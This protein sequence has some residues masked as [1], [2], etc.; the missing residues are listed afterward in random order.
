MKLFLTLLL[1]SSTACAVAPAKTIETL[2]TEYIQLNLSMTPHDGSFVDAYYGPAALQEQAVK[3]PMS[4]DEIKSQAT[5]MLSD[6]SKIPTPKAESMEALRI[7]YLQKQTTAM[8]GRIDLL[9]AKKM[10]FDQE[11]AILYDA[12]A[13]H[14]DRSHFEA[15]IKQIDT[16]LPGSGTTVERVKAFR[17]QFIIPRDKLMVV[18]ET[19]IQACR[20][21][22]LKHITLPEG[23]DFKLEFVTGKV[24]SGYNWYK[25]NYQSLI[26]INVELPIY[27]ERAIDIG[28]HE[29]YPGHHTYNVLLEKNLVNERKWLEY[30]VY[31]L[32][33]PQSLIAEGT[34]NYGVEMAFPEALKKNFQRDVLYP[35]AGI[36]PAL[37][38]KYDALLKL[39]AQLNY[40]GNEAAREYIDG[41][42]TREQAID[43][44]INV[45]L[46]PVE[47]APQRV[48]FFDVNRSYVINYNLGKDLVKDYVEY[49]SR[50][51]GTEADKTALRWQVFEKLISSPLLP[52]NLKVESG[53]S[54]PK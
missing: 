28:C 52:S 17:S 26:Q 15:I 6:L 16:L 31:P 10:S 5:L 39:T 54:T 40:A 37:L 35:L 47:K 32:Y 44:L 21:Q 29:G 30:S 34:A 36:N 14:Y 7:A 33:S 43:W 23:E 3:S 19:A 9:Q 20:E 18:F 41:K 12:V 4:L 13:P 50:S 27:I 1:A 22:T 8:L 46:Y 42:M 45:E 48:S 49:N 38:D 24:W 51:S 2:A 11:S 53:P 25:G